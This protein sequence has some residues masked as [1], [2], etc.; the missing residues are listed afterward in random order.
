VIRTIY[1]ISIHF[2]KDWRKDLNKA[3]DECLKPY[4]KHVEEFEYFEGNPA[5]NPYVI[6]ETD[7]LL[8]AQLIE[9]S[10]Q[11]TLLKLKCR[12]DDFDR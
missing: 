10:V 2:Q 5:C 1:R 11:R 4:S 6:I 12:L 8:N 9:E 3:L 7:S